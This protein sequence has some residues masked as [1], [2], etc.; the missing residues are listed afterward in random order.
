MPLTDAAIRRA[1]ARNKPYK[2]FDSG[3]L[4]LLISPAGGR[5][6]RF[7]Y[8]FADKEKLLSL[9]VYPDIS[10]RE[11]RDRRDR[12]RRKLVGQ[13]DPGV[14]RSAA[15]A[16]RAGNDTNSFEVVAREWIEKKSSS[17]S[18]SNKS[19]TVRRLEVDAFPWIG[20]RPIAEISPPELLSALR[21]TEGR[22]AVD[23]AH[24]VLQTCG[25]IF[26]IKERDDFG[27]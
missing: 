16:A 3:G 7:K 10:L 12:E 1:K 15:K 21:R 13:V 23:T 17:W 27:V 14:R 24:R 22:G 20:K 19:K 4:F 2:M 8:R 26:R 25:Q 18:A 9:G 6:W 5:W 11:A